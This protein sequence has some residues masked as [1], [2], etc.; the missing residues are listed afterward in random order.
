MPDTALQRTVRRG[1]ALLLLP[2]SGVAIGLERFVWS[3]FYGATPPSLLGVLAFDLVPIGLF[4]GALGYLVS[5]GLR[6]F[7]T[8]L[9]AETED[10]DAGDSTGPTD[11]S[12]EGDSTGPT[13]GTNH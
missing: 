11:G 6:G 7:A 8:E 10:G 5:S 12:A 2:L 13:D 4:L 3:D 1:V 9:T